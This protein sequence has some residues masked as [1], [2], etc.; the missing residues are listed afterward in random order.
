MR[1]RGFQDRKQHAPPNVSPPTQTTGQQGPPRSLSN[2]CLQDEEPASQTYGATSVF[3]GLTWQ[4]A[5]S[6]MRRLKGI[7]VLSVFAPGKREDHVI[8]EAGCAHTLGSIFA[9]EPRDHCTRFCARI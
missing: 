8:C 6:E 5:L 9:V 4:E 2:S 7:G 3:T 1:T